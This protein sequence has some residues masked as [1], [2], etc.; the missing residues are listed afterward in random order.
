MI[1]ALCPHFRDDELDEIFGEDEPGDDACVD[2]G[3]GVNPCARDPYHADHGSTAESEAV[4][5]AHVWVV[6]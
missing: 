2:A 5:G 3:S 6:L 1:D 4:W